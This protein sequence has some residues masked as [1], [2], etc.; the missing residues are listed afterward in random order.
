M[1]GLWMICLPV[2][3]RFLC[4]SR[5]IALVL[6][7]GQRLIVGQPARQ[8]IESKT[9]MC[10]HPGV[11]STPKSATLRASLQ[12]SQRLVLV[13][14][15]TMSLMPL[16]RL[17][18][19]SRRRAE[20][21]PSR[22]SAA[23]WL[24]CSFLPSQLANSASA[25]SALMVRPTVRF[26]VQYCASSHSSATS[27]AGLLLFQDILHSVTGSM[28]SRLIAPSKICSMRSRNLW[29][30]AAVQSDLGFSL[31]R[32]QAASDRSCL[33]S[34]GDNVIDSAPA[35]QGRSYHNMPSRSTHQ[36]CALLHTTLPRLQCD[37]AA[38]QNCRQFRFRLSR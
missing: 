32:I 15:Q 28:T 33:I 31:L 34:A 11:I 1:L 37:S 38:L 4:R 22:C 20:W 23:A 10:D 9:P 36:K 25:P 7:E 2:K 27:S 29:L 26:H 6:L 14:Q 35:K 17:A 18:T 24:A 21:W 3:K 8:L 30:S 5:R 13:V 19:R 12:M 16:K